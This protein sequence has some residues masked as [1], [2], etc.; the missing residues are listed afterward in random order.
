MVRLRSEREREGVASGLPL[1]AALASTLH[2]HSM[3]LATYSGARSD[4]DEK[5]G[6]KAKAQSRSRKKELEE[7]R[8]AKVVSL[9]VLFEAGCF[10]SLCWFLR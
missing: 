1:L 4:E 10:F 2:I 8:R 9:V 3:K 7:Q 5:L 6:E